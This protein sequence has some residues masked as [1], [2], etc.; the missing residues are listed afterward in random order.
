MRRARPAV[1]EEDH[2]RSRGVYSDGSPADASAPGSSPL[3]RGLHHPDFPAQARRRIIPAR[4]GFTSGRGAAS[5]SP[6]DHPRSRG[7]YLLGLP[8]GVLPGGSSPLAR[9]LPQLLG[10]VHDDDG[11]IPARAGFTPP[12]LPRPGPPPDHPRSRGVYLLGLPPGVLPGGSSPLARGLRR[13]R[14]ARP[15]MGGIIPARAGFTHVPDHRPLR[16]PD[17]PRSRGVYA[18]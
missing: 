18:W 11:I 4:A 17:H 7:V 14:R 16:R 8:P 5:G 13:P 1:P 3:A 6:T 15:R 9:G 12:G 10:L 2:P